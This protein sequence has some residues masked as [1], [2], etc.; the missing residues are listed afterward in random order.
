MDV[1]ISLP[2]PENTSGK[3]IKKFLRQ[4]ELCVHYLKKTVEE[5]EENEG[6]EE[7]DNYYLIYKFPAINSRETDNDS[8]MKVHID[9]LSDELQ[10]IE[11]QINHI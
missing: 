2:K 3:D 4:M 7:L 11:V 9:E 5:I 1:K 10:E 6:K 8:Y